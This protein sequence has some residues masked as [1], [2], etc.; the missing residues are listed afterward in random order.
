MGTVN[1]LLDTHAFLWAVRDEEKL[2]ETAKAAITKNSS[3][4]YVSSVSAYEIMNKYRLGKL[5]DYWAVCMAA[6][7]FSAA[8]TA[9]RVSWRCHAVKRGDHLNAAFFNRA[10]CSQSGF[11][12][13]MI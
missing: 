12:S 11:S 1:Y 8:S 3:N 10:R 13:K 6:R 2:S 4:I 7:T 9:F 5:P